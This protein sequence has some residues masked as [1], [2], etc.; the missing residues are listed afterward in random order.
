MDLQSILPRFAIVDTA[1]QHDSVRAKELCAGLSERKIVLFD[2][3]YVNLVH[4][5]ALASR[6][7]FF[8]TRAKDKI[9]F[10]VKLIGKF[11]RTN[12]MV[13]IPI[14]LEIHGF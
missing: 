13:D 6:G 4:L 8:V 7:V 12:H 14:Q 1:R 11:D 2:N 10:E 5:W 9:A 3:A